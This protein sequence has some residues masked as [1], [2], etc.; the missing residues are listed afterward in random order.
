MSRPAPADQ[1]WGP[2]P[3]EPPRP[4]RG[5]FDPIRVLVVDDSEAI[6]RSVRELIA[7]APGVVL[8]GEAETGEKSLVMIRECRPEVVLMDV[9]MP[10][11]G[12]VEAARLTRRECPDA[13]I[14]MHSVYEDVDYM[15]AARDVGA[16]AYVL[17]GCGSDLLLHMIH[18]AGQFSRSR[19]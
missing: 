16:Y 15:E 11:M 18:T 4:A 2:R 17:K 13:V 12:G 14:L 1:P 19:P 7:D 5:P 6:R 8:A 3:A 9:K 10:G